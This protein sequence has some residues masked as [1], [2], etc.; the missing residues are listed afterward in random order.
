MGYTTYSKAI[1]RYDLIIASLKE[2]F[3]LSSEE[4]IRFSKLKRR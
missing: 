1:D 2:P 4:N 3:A